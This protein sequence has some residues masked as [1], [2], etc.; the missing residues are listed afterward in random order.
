MK[1][2]LE[3]AI[4]EK[5]HKEIR[6]LELKSKSSN[7]LYFFESGDDKLVLKTPNLKLSALSPFWKQLRHVFGSDFITHA[8]NAV[9]LE[10]YLSRNP[11]IK[12]PKVIGTNVKERVFQ[13]FQHMEG[14]FYEPDEFP[15]EE[16][17]NY[18]LGQYI[19]WLHSQKFQGYGIFSDNLKLNN[20]SKFLE[21]VLCSMDKTINEYWSFNQ[22][23]I[24]FY[25][26]IERVIPDDIGSFSLIMPDISG[27]QFVYSKDLKRINAVVDLDAYVIGPINFELTV[28]EMCLTNYSS[29]QKGYEQYCSLPCFKS[30]RSFY[31]FLMYLNDPYDH[32]DL[33][34]FLNSNIFFS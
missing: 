29:F 22:E 1:K 32:G 28:L 18:Q 27:N 5:L 10:K 17:L 12:V 31:R 13:I 15:V 14:G 11:H 23:V 34:S 6:N 2:E 25:R 26:D 9:T 16:E 4:Q 21:E 19:G 24:N 3:K 33:E 20:C 8:E 30:F 7:Q